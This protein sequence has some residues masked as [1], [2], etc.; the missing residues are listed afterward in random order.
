M[1]TLRGAAYDEIKRI[2]REDEPSKPST[3]L[4][5]LGQDLDTVARQRATEPRKLGSTL[6]G[7]LDWI[8][9]K[10]MDKDRTRRYESSNGLAMDIERY[11]ANEAVTA[12]PPSASYRMRKFVRRNRVSVVTGALVVL[13]LALGVIG[14]SSGMIRAMHERDRADAAAQAESTARIEAQLQAD[15]AQAVNDF[16]T[17]DLLGAVDPTRTQDREIAMRDVVDE[18]SLR[19][20]TRFKNQPYIAATVERTLGDIY[21]RLGVFA[22]AEN[23]FRHAQEL[24]LASPGEHGRDAL[25]VRGDLNTLQFYAGRYEQGIEDTQATLAVMLDTLGEDDLVTLNTMSLLAMLYTWHNQLD[26]AE[27][28]FLRALAGLDRTVGP[29]HRDT[30]SVRN[31]LAILYSDR[32]DLDKAVELLDSVYEVMVAEY[33]QND[34]DTLDSMVNLA[35][36]YNEMGRLDEAEEIGRKSLDAARRTLGDEHPTTLNA[37]N[38][39][40]VTYVRKGEY[41]LAEPLYVEDFE[42]SRRILGAEHPET[43]V[44]MA[45]LG[46]LY[47]RMER[48]EDAVR[49]LSECAALNEKVLPPGHFGIGVTL[50]SL[51][52]SLLGLGRPEEALPRLVDAYDGLLPVLGP[53]NPDIRGLI[54]KIATA[55]EQSSDTEAAA[56]WRAKLQ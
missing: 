7:D 9:M 33:G 19:I 40:A 12:G 27:P 37:M 31:N 20:A 22:N 50:R 32:R 35:H 34:P 3:R 5:N 39:L 28:L 1:K 43:L 29:T 13:A 38:N 21:T 48:Y 56:R 25:A 42:T 18:A 47:M 6:R 41:D 52:E 15:R 55:Y 11:L 16:L 54:E 44:S 49:V 10:A 8:I 23:H 46:R 36:V 4:S 51:G 2:I 17:D 53:E 14:T 26:E 45:N 30:L 24:L